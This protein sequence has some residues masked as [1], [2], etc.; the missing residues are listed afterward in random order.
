LRRYQQ[1]VD[2]NTTEIVEAF[3]ALGVS[4]EVV[5]DLFDLVVGYGGIS[6]IV[7]VKMPK[8]KIKAGRQ[9]KFHD[10][11]TG[12]IR[13]VRSVEDVAATVATLR[14]WHSLLTALPVAP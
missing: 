9:Q 8:A 2:G 6:M 7:E 13:L 14:R 1:R 11:W 5:N 12:G 4:C 3:R 10:R